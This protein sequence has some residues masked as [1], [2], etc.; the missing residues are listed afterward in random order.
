MNILDVIQEKRNFV[1]VTIDG[2]RCHKQKY[3]L[4]I[5]LKELHLV[6]LNTTDHKIGFSK[7]C[8]LCLKWCVTVDST[9]GVHSVY[10]KYIRMQNYYMLLYQVRLI[11]RNFYQNLYVILAIGAAYYI[12]VIVAQTYMK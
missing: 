5:N 7:F 12:P 3:L 1:S 11:I 4:L 8:Q 2:V 9:S 10:V 6:F